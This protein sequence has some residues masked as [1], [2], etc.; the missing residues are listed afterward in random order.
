MA[1]PVTLTGAAVGAANS[2]HGPFKSNDGKFYAILNDV[3]DTSLLEAHMATDPTDSW[4]VQDDSNK[5]DFNSV[6]TSVW[7]FQKADIIY[8]A[9]QNQTED[10]YHAQFN[11]AADAWV[12]ISGGNTEFLVVDLASE[13]QANAVSIAVE[14]SS[15][16]EIVIA[17][18]GNPSE[19]KDMGGSF[20]WVAY[21]VSDDA[22]VGA[23]W[24]TENAVADTDDASEVDFTGPV[25]VR[26]S[27]GVR[28]HIFFKDDTNDDAYQRTLADPGGTPALETF[29]SALDAEV[30]TTSFY[31]FD[32]GV[33]L[34]DTVYCPYIDNGGTISVASLV[35]ADA[36]TVSVT[37]GVSD[38]SVNFNFGLALDGGDLHILFSDAADEDVMHD[39]NTG[40]GWGTDAQVGDARTASNGVYP[41]I[42]D[43]DGPKIG[44]IYGDPITVKYDELAITHTFGLLSDVNMGKQNSFHGPFET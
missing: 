7:C 32:R 21:A 11:M 34:D 24:S 31:I 33:L 22:G 12:D 42:Y 26:G 38:A 30:L 18:Q 1:L 5:P 35:S 23:S 17:Y 20:E 2:Y 3:G 29:P 15:S 19:N 16:N 27:D 10:V 4:A 14:E 13:T 43:R 25:I 28:M 8:V 9:A 39:I 36:P 6:N 40:S 44:F 37:T 41:N